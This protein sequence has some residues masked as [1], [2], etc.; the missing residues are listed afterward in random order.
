MK[1]I[2]NRTIQNLLPTS[3]LHAP[4]GR[5]LFRSRTLTPPEPSCALFVPK[6]SRSGKEYGRVSAIGTKRGEAEAL[7]FCGVSNV[8]VGEG[9]GE[10]YCQNVD[11][12]PADGSFRLHLRAPKAPILPYRL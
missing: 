4:P 2:R 6:W 10:G 7:S 3:M 5:P 8:T 11:T 12:G 9:L 1:T